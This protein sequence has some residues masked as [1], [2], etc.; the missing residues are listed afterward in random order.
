MLVVM[1]VFPYIM[2]AIITKYSDLQDWNDTLHAYCLHWIVY[3]LLMYNVNTCHVQ[4]KPED[5]FVHEMPCHW[6]QI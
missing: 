4:T 5:F 1:C 2:L 6:I 3:L